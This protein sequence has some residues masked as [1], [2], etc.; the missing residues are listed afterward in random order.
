MTSDSPAGVFDRL[1]LEPLSTVD[2][3]AEELR[4]ALFAGEL[5]PGTPLREVAL[6]DSLNVARS[7]VREALGVLVAEGLADRVAHR[8]TQVRALDHAAVADLTRARA[9]AETAGVRRWAE[10]DDEARDGVRRA[11]RDYA[12]T[13]AAEPAPAEMAEAHLAV[14]RA[15]VGLTGSQRLL[16]AADGWYAELRLTL[17]G[18]DRARANAA[19]QVH[20]HTALVDLLEQGRID[21]AAAELAAH[22]E[23]ARTSL[24]DELPPPPA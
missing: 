13:A 3:I 17:A 7:T 16:D 9:V 6:A 19:E 18:L 23:D 12:A 15:L 11:L 20:A 1:S 22:L 10:A 21:E 8:G 24:T 5:P 4:R 14:H 2:R